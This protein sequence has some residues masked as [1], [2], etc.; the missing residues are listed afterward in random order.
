MTPFTLFAIITV[1]A[2]VMF[3]LT[4]A[5]STA[6]DVVGQIRKALKRAYAHP[7]FV[8]VATMT[9]CVIGALVW[10]PELLFA[11][12]FAVGSLSEGRHTGEFIISEANGQLSRDNVTVTV[13]AATKFQ[14]GTVLGQVTATG[15]YVAFDETASDGRENAAGVLYGECNNEDGVGATDVAAAV[16]NMNAEVREAD[17]I[18]VNDA[19]DAQGLADLL[20]L[21]IK[22]R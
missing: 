18:W 2:V 16:V 19:D 20:A 14:P 4:F 7:L 5:R 15:K 9:A 22:A 17:L 1:L 13:P 21:G 6:G 3:V 10:R 11:A 12:P 8:P